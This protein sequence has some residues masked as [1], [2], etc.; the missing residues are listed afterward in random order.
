MPPNPLVSISI[1]VIDDGDHLLAC[2]D[3]IRANTGGS[4]PYEVLVV[5]NGA[6]Q[7]T[8]LRLR[9]RDDI[10]LIRSGVNLGFGGGHNWA[11]RFA[12]GAYL[13][14]LNDDSTVETGWMD[15]LVKT[16]TGH[17]GAGAVGSRVLYPDGRLQEAGG[18]IWRDGSSERI[19]RFLPPGTVEFAAIR[20][21]EYCS[22]CSLLVRREAWD[23]LG[24]FAPEYFPAYYE[25]VDLC[26]RL[27]ESGFDVLYDPS[28]RIRHLES[29]STDQT[30]RVF[31]SETNR[32]RFVDR[33]KEVLDGH[34]PAP[35]PGA[36]DAAIFRSARTLDPRP[37]LLVVDRQPPTT[38]L[39][40]A[41]ELG[42]LHR[43]AATMAVHVWLEDPAS[44]GPSLADRLGENGIHL[45]DGRLRPLP[46]VL[47]WGWDSVV[48][49]HTKAEDEALT[50]A[51][52]ATNPRE[53]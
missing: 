34:E 20:P 53:A 8:L 46:E 33:W 31:V 22:G 51:D 35:P 32:A 11:A 17:P 45:L 16:A 40:E 41:G 5:A 37:T 1:L 49:P 15:S 36:L 3:S 21:V 26:F 24:G 39:T 50:G 30:W 47:G 13:L 14:L 19:G 7:S 23:A 2:L 27:R 38:P 25:D 42:W 18:I 6:P 12:R 43:Q 10:V 9:E 48:E 4:V 44:L 28:S 52:G 29:G